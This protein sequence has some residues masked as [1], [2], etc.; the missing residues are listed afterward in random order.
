M[1]WD[2]N[3]GKNDYPLTGATGGIYNITQSPDANYIIPLTGSNKVTVLNTTTGRIAF[4]L[5]HIETVLN[6][7]YSN[8]GKFIVS[9]SWDSTIKVWDALKAELKFSYKT[10][11]GIKDVIFSSINKEIIIAEEHLISVFDFITNKKKIQYP[12][13]DRTIQ[14]YSL[15]KTLSL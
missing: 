13:S 9:Q 5:N 14:H 6:T 3:T 8:D 12:F 11:A 7:K 4:K 10:K 15:L 1:L 2:I